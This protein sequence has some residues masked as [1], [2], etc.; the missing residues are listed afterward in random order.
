[1]VNRV[2]RGRK[3]QVAQVKGT[4]RYKPPVLKHISHGDAMYGTGDVV[5]PVVGASYG[6]RW[7]LD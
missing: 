7:Q 6:D 5:H 3:G 1:M 4:E 2:G